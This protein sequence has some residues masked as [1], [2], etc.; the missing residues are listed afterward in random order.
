M[1]AAIPKRKLH[2]IHAFY[3]TCSCTAY[4]KAW[5]ARELSLS[6]RMLA[7]MH[8]LG[9]PTVIVRTVECTIVSVMIYTGIMLVSMQKRTLLSIGTAWTGTLH[10]QR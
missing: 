3:M 8:I 6:M 4:V 9:G 10:E 2:S 7:N 1:S 5:T